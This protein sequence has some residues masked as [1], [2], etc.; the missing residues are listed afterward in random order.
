[1]GYQ[2]RVH[3][4][5]TSNPTANLNELTTTMSYNYLSRYPFAL[6]DKYSRIDAMMDIRRKSIR[7][8]S[9]MD[10]MMM[11]NLDVVKE[12]YINEF[13]SPQP[14]T[15]QGF[16]YPKF[17]ANEAGSPHVSYLPRPY[18]NYRLPSR[19]S[20]TKYRSARTT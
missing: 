17:E 4:E 10:E 13:L 3:G 12:R 19:C 16:Y 5:S 8:K 20:Y 9:E 15:S 14:A 6:Q 7:A 18:L 2:R 11:N 1:M